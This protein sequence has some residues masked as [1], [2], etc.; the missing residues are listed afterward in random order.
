MEYNAETLKNIIIAWQKI[1][2]YDET[3]LEFL[4]KEH[5]KVIEEVN[6]RLRPEDL[7]SPFALSKKYMILGAMCGGN[8]VIGP[9][10]LLRE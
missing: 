10:G 5:P 7:R 1:K 8:C 2:K 3:L 9:D 6:K 4:E